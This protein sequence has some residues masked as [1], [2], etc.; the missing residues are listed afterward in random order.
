ML[1]SVDILLKLCIILEYCLILFI[2]RSSS[3]AVRRKSFSKHHFNALVLISPPPCSSLHKTLRIGA[4]CNNNIGELV[5]LR[6]DDWC[7]E[8]HL[9]ITREEIKD[10][11]AGTYYVAEHTKTYSD[12][13]VVLVPKAKEILSRIDHQGNYI[14]MRDGERLT[15]RQV[16]YVLEKYAERQ[17]V[18][19]KSTHKMRKTY[20]SMVFNISSNGSGSGECI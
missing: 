20:T 13:F 3:D 18:Q 12:R 11:E 8:N 7:D 2:R 10:Q 17:G 4:I 16:A 1:S 14:F 9:H 19:T 15:S 6:W 5:A